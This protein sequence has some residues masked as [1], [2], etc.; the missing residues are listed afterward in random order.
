MGKDLPHSTDPAYASAALVAV[1]WFEDLM[2]SVIP[3][4]ETNPI[5]PTFLQLILHCKV[6]FATSPGEVIQRFNK[7]KKLQRLCNKVF[8][9]MNRA[10]RGFVA[11][12]FWRGQGGQ[13]KENLDF[14]SIIKRFEGFCN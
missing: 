4:C 1:G 14:F 3:N 6:S 11:K 12:R 7:N 9:A 2:V 10:N 8:I 5:E 13:E